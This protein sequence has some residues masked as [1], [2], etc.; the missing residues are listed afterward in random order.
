MAV[1]EKMVNGARF[2]FYKQ[3]W[4]SQRPVIEKWKQ[5][6]ALRVK[7]SILV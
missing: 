4:Q 5:H 1:L 7:D 6:Y 3:W 2:A